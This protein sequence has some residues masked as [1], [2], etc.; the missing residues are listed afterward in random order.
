[1]S[2]LLESNQRSNKPVTRLYDPTGAQVLEGSKWQIRYGDKSTAGGKVFLDKVTIGELTVPKQA[3]EAATTMSSSFTRGGSMDGLIGL[4]SGKLNTIKPKGQPTWFENIRGQ[5]AQPVFTSALKRHA[6]GAFDFGF[7]DRKKYSGDI[8]WVPV[9]GAKGF[10]DFSING[11]AVDKGPTI[12]TEASAI[13]DTG[14]SLWYAAPDMVN[15]YWNKSGGTYSQVQGG[16]TFPCSS[17]LLDIAVVIGGKKFT[18]AGQNM[19]YQTLSPATCFGGLQRN[20]GMPFSIYGD[21]FLKSLYVIF[22]Q[23]PGA[24]QRLGFAQAT[25]P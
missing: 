20:T 16:F 1:M 4:A 5:L 17:K 22:E 25:S 10:W 24:P 9:K 8:A 3:V 14:S 13:I 18:I 2:T 23:K 19:N 12:N 6:A 21:V 7:I 15:A 11:Y